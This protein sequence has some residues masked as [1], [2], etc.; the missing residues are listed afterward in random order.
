MSQKL[1]SMEQIKQILQLK[2]DGIP[3]REIA[4]RIGVSRNSVKKYLTRL[5]EHTDEALSAKQLADAAYDNEALSKANNRLE[6]LYQ[7]LGYAMDEIRKTGV[8]RQLLWLEYIAAH[9]QGYNYSR[10]CYH[11]KEYQQHKDVA[12]NKVYDPGDMI[13]IDFAGEKLSYVQRETGEVIECAVFVAT[14][15][16]SGLVFCTA[17]LTQ[18]TKDVCHC[19]AAMLKFYGGVPVT[20]LCD[21]MAT[22]V[23]RY[24]KFEPRFT[25]LCY[26]LA[27]HYDTTFSAARP[28]KPRDKAPV[29]RNV[30]IVYQNI[31]ALIRHQTFHSLSELNEAIA[32][33]LNSLNNKEGFRMAVYSRWYLFDVY[34]KQLLRPL[35]S[36]PFRLK[37]SIYRT[38]DRNYC[39]RLPEDGVK[40]S[41]PYRYV[42][43]EVKLVYDNHSLEVY[44]DF[45]RIA[46]HSR[47]HDGKLYK[48]QPEHEPPSH[49]YM[50]ETR[51]WTM[52]GLLK[53]AERVGPYS[54]QAAERI[55]NSSINAQQNYKCCNAMV[56]LQNKYGQSR[57]EAACRRAVTGSLRVN[58]GMVQDILRRGLDK[59]PLLFDESPLPEHEN[60]RG[61]YE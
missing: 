20:I 3:I 31:Y 61:D 11:F 47:Q 9:P 25:Q 40:Y 46:V 8:T 50:N 38:V 5:D 42:G 37:K 18:Q 35:P 16:Y 55:L 44:Y 28:R 53:Q 36:E 17:V 58:L 4:R 23:T 41:V 26:Q 27:D 54:H 21:N 39:V 43:K 56:L 12:Y 48:I 7:H 33:H 13:M 34:E 52:E 15:P 6:A 51:G 14:M 29:E 45:E 19:I 59:Q 1:L 32:Q 30:T 60:I 57:L 10:Y 24:D 22:A 49:Q 2:R